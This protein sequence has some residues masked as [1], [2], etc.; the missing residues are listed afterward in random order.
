MIPTVRD[1]MT[2]SFIKLDSD[3]KVVG[4]Y[5]ALQG[6]AGQVGVVLH[7]G[8][9]VTVITHT[10]LEQQLGVP[11]QRL[12]DMLAKLPPGII[13]D[14]DTTLETFV[15]SSEFTALD[16]GARGAIVMDQ[17]QVVGILSE[18]TI[19]G[20]LAQEYESLIRTKG[21][22]G[23]D[24]SIVTPRVIKYCDEFGHRNELKYFSRHKIPDCQVRQ[25]RVHPLIRKA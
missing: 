20:Y 9:P 14:P 21:D 1:R 23:L 3:E 12:S 16:E 13:A 6:Q 2:T 24:G 22:T 7:E 18:K 17:G 15:N 5:A 11:D 25:P 4:A 10:D 19:D 8:Q